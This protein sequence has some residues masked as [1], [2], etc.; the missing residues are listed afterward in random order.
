MRLIEQE[1][2]EGIAEPIKLSAA[3]DEPLGVNYKYN[4]TEKARLDNEP[5]ASIE[6]TELPKNGKILTKK[7]DGNTRE[8]KI[9]DFISTEEL[10]EFQYDQDDKICTKDTKENCEDSFSYITYSS[11]VGQGPE[12]EAQI[13]LKPVPKIIREEPK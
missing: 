5:P 8:L 13:N 11:W 4:V 2:V 12:A 6:I 1:V 7:I 10:N 3:F 9:G